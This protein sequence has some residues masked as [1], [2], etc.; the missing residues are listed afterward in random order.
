MKTIEDLNALLD[1]TFQRVLDF[2]GRSGELATD[3][4]RS[5][6]PTAEEDTE[7]FGVAAND[8]QEL[9]DGDDVDETA[10]GG[11]PQL[12]NLQR[13]RDERRPRDI[14]SVAVLGV[15]PDGQ[16]VEFDTEKWLAS[17]SNPSDVMIAEARANNPNNKRGWIGVY[18]DKIVCLFTGRHLKILGAHLRRLFKNDPNFSSFATHAGYIEGLKLPIDYPKA[19]PYL[20]TIR[21][22]V[23]A[24]RGKGDTGRPAELQQKIDKVLAKTGFDLSLRDKPATRPGNFP[25]FVVCLECGESMHDIRPHL[26]DKHG[27]YYDRY[28][29]D[30]QISGRAPATGEE[31]MDFASTRKHA[32][33]MLEQLGIPASEQVK[34]AR[35]PGVLKDKILC[36]IDGQLVDDL[37]Q[38]L[39]SRGLAPIK[40]Y[41][42]RYELPSNY[43]TTPPSRPPAEGDSTAK[44]AAPVKR[45]PASRAKPAAKGAAATRAAAPASAPANDHAA[46]PA[47]ASRQEA[48]E[49]ES[50]A[51]DDGNLSLLSERLQKDLEAFKKR[52]AAP[53][54]ALPSPAASTVL[55]MTGRTSVETRVIESKS[56]A[57][58]VTIERR[59]AKLRLRK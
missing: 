12:P 39:T 17:F 49:V 22:D 37:A 25:D 51:D 59:P 52:K 46:S 29:R 27:T 45:K 7:S 21:T 38:H 18:D 31:G 33:E 35:W 58:P 23:A 24:R 19:A 15:G 41:L 54:A 8:Q 42:A 34:P 3:V 28:K 32:A 16:P 30:W 13:I 57:Q 48:P 6:A 56:G 43:P 2:A 26:R 9:G 44:K 14:P 53:A 47:A 10:N 4:V 5:T 36:M 55:P 20:S 40:H 11:K 50:V 1:S